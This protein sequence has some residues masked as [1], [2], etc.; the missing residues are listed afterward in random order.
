MTAPIRVGIVGAGFF[1]GM[2]ARACAQ[3]PSFA[4][5]A[6]TDV[7]VEAAARLADE[8]GAAVAD[9]HTALA[10][11]DDVDLVMIATPNHLHVEPA[12]A[13][14]G[15]SKHVFVEK[16]VAI[17][18]H[19]IDRMLEAAQ[20][21]TGILIVGHVMRAFPGVRRMVAEAR[22]GEL[23][24]L[25]EVAGARRR[26]VHPPADPG[27][28]WKFDRRR[29]GG[30]LLH[31]IH[32]LDL[33]VWAIGDDEIAESAE[34]RHLAGA[35]LLH[36]AHTIDTDDVTTLRTASGVVGR[37]SVSTSAHRAEWW[38]RIAGTTATLEADFRAGTVTRFVDGAPVAVTGVF[39]DDESNQSLRDSAERPQA[40]NAAGSAGPIWMRTAVVCELDEVAAAVHDI[41]STLTEIPA[42][43]ARVAIRARGAE[44]AS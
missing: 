14:L 29:S 5:T 28:W 18:E 39:D 15:A 42:A 33:M 24:D 40:Y 17:D 38:F 44:V 6:I 35:P 34:I 7:S 16:P 10:R 37:H 20:A 3:H 2:I 22:A 36:G 8:H 23:G 41:S 30:E 32:E 19:D 26:V 12:I 11:R 9:D 1:G 13:A 31:E 4:V 25:L 27:D 21:S 43:A